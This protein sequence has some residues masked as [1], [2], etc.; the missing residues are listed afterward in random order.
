MPA[1]ERQR[2]HQPRH[3]PAV[4]AAPDDHQHHEAAEAHG[5]A[6]Q[7]Q[8]VH[9]R[10]FLR[11]EEGPHDQ[12]QRRRQ[13][14]QREAPDERLDARALVV[15]GVGQ[16]DAEQQRV[17]PQVG[18]RVDARPRVAERLGRE[19]AAGQ[20]GRAGQRDQ[21]GGALQVAA[22]LAPAGVGHEAQP[23]QQVEVLL[24]GQRP[25]VVPQG[26]E[27]VLDEQDLGQQPL[28]EGGRPLALPVLDDGHD[29]DHHV[30]ARVDLEAAPH[31]EA[32]DV[33]LAVLRVLAEEQA[34][35][36]ETAQHEEQV[37]AGPARA[38]HDARD[39]RG[40]AVDELRPVVADDQQDGRRAQHVQ[41]GKAALRRR[42]GPGPVGPR[43]G[44][45]HA[46]SRP[47]HQAMFV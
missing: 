3:A 22:Q 11:Q 31:E 19:V 14:R 44:S 18:R 43:R 41:F 16:A 42:S 2:R 30:E 21:D 17:Q 28:P 15:V 7:P 27:V 24:D 39:D 47:G 5:Q 6:Q 33:H 29:G 10:R 8:R 4:L 23:Q 34:G 38:P 26:P 1:R 32:Q 13:Q 9:E 20:A 12:R 45:R 40:V 35:D 37:D 46:I 25:G 36:Q